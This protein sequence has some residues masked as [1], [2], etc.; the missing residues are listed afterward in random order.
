METVLLAKTA[1]SPPREF[2]ALLNSDQKGAATA[3][4]IQGHECTL[5]RDRDLSNHM[6]HVV[7]SEQ[8]D[9]YYTAQAIR[10]VQEVGFREVRKM[11]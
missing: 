4:T 11:P 3:I 2:A 5:V 6:C 10:L 1:D 9:G 7:R 8:L